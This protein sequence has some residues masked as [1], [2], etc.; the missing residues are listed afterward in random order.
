MKKAPKTW[1]PTKYNHLYRHKSGVY[2]ARIS[3]AGKKTWRSLQTSVLGIAKAEL[4]KK[5]EDAAHL[6]EISQVKPVSERMTGSEAI[7]LRKEQIDNDPSI[8]SST[9]SYWDEII[10][11]LEK[12]WPEFLAT[13]LRQISQEACEAWAGK[14]K[15]SMSPTRFNNTLSLIKSLFEIAIKNGVRRTNPASES[16]RMKLRSKDLSQLLP[17]LKEFKTW[18]DAIRNAGGRFSKDCADFV[19]FL[20][21]TGM[22]TGEAKWVQ[23]KHCDFDRGEIVVVGDPEEA[24][25]NGEIRR[26]P[27]IAA[28]R[29]LLTRMKR[30]RLKETS[31]SSVLKV[32][33]AQKAMNRAFTDLGME[34]FTHHDLRHY[35][36]TI[37]IESGVDIPTVSKWLGHKDGGALAM[38][39]Y[40]HLR[41]EHSIA[42]AGKVSF[43]A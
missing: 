26:V 22:R 30:E 40:G 9:R 35:F 37:C 21:Y 28:S 15:D 5:L 33:E 19:E 1:N 23:W 20:A 4:D 14:N 43:A 2:Y 7:Q 39:T 17:S 27:M 38:R 8:K 24:T 42:A 18:V 36:A 41:N 6:N 29:E 3:L 13:E 34:R 12:S 31:V 10:A 25:K 16:K 11:A 32:R